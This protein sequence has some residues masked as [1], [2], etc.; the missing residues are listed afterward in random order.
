MQTTR[1]CIYKK[2]VY[3]LTRDVRAGGA[4]AIQ[5]PVVALFGAEIVV[6]GVLLPEG[7][8]EMKRNIYSTRFRSAVQSSE[9]VG[10]R[11]FI[12]EGLQVLEV[13]FWLL[14]GCRIYFEGAPMVEN[15]PFPAR[16]APLLAGGVPY[17]LRRATSWTKRAPSPFRW[18]Y[19]L[20]GRSPYNAFGAKADPGLR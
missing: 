7:S 2:Y 20:A 9:W 10:S 5:K 17:L 18:A 12:G 6:V 15:A 3:L 8:S 11:I 13:P 4:G 14:K 16:R 19:S 1:Y